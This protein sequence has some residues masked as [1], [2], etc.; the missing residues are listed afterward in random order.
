MCVN[1]HYMGGAEQT[2]LL[3]Y[4]SYNADPCLLYKVNLSMPHSSKLMGRSNWAQGKDIK[5]YPK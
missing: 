1:E 2:T 5:L 4:A 3:Q